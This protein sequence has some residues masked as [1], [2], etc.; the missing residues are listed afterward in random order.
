M[1]KFP[2]TDQNTHMTTTPIL[3]VGSGAMASLFAARLA[4]S[5]QPVLMYDTWADAVQSISQNGIHLTT[6][7]GEVISVT[8]PITDSLEA[9]PPVQYALVL[10]KSWQT[11]ASANC[12]RR[13]LKDDGIT[14]T[15]QNGLGNLETLEQA[16]GKRRC[17][18]G[19]ATL[20]AHLTAPGFVQQAGNAELAIG[21][22]SRLQNFP[23]MLT[24]AG[25]V[26]SLQDNLES[27]L[28]GKLV[29]NAAVNPITALLD[30]PN[31]ALL[32][33]P[34]AFH[35]M[36]QI[37]NEIESTTAKLKIPLPYPCA[38][39]HVI[40]V[41]LNTAGNVSSML[42]DFRNKRLTE[43]DA[44]N[45]AVVQY[46]QQAGVSVPVNETLVQL[47]HARETASNG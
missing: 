5:S 46:A 37:I 8:V 30:I 17:T 40:Q 7:S 2:E 31:G 10:V 18:A 41:I 35:L 39:D 32:E 43:I 14:L 4:I 28:W 1:G 6:P 15:L 16:L 45:G 23:Q 11:S 27:L 36:Q 26:I 44:I 20:G 3:I 9:V 29:V 13:V 47:I 21:N 34:A 38:V 24:D 25:F 42:Q 33:N 19:A 12:L 22:H